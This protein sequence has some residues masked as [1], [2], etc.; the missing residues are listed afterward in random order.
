MPENGTS[1][2]RRKVLFRGGRRPWLLLDAGRD[3]QG[4]DLIEFPDAAFWMITRRKITLDKVQVK[5]YI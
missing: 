3:H 1:A 5:E 4:L 2:T